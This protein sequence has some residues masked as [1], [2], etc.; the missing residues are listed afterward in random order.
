MRVKT[1]LVR[2][3]QNEEEEVEEHIVVTS[4]RSRDFPLGPT[5][6]PPPPPPP[7]CTVFIL[8][9]KAFF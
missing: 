4:H 1:H 6:P 8:R 3:C 2:A 7:L 9:L 5:P